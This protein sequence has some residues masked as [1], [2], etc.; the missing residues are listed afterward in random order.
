MQSAN[1]VAR[2]PAQFVKPASYQDLSIRLHCYAAHDVVRARIEGAVHGAVRV[3]SAD[4]GARQAA[5]LGEFATDQ[6]LSI[7]LDGEAKD[8]TGERRSSTTSPRID[9]A[10]KAD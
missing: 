3:Q 7:Q 2:L 8:R 5:Q 6:H 10:I 1:M 4:I 9:S